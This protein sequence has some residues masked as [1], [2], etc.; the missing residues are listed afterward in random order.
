MTIFIDKELPMNSEYDMHCDEIGLKSVRA[1]MGY[2][3]LIPDYQ[4]GYRWKQQQV[5]DL[6]DDISEFM[7]RKSS[8]KDNFYCLQPLVVKETIAKPD[9]FIT[10]LP[11]EGK[12][13]L[14]K[15]RQAIVNHVE[16]EVID[17]QQ[18]LTTIYLILFFLTET[19]DSKRDN[20]YTLRYMT[21]DSSGE[22]LKNISRKTLEDSRENIDF[23]HMFEA[24]ATI[25]K[26]F[27]QNNSRQNDEYKKRFYN[28]LFDKVKFIWY[29]AVDK[30]PISVF[31]RLNIGKIPLTNAELI[32]ALFL[33]R[34][35]EEDLDKTRTRQ[36]EIASQWDEI[37]NTLQNDEFWM[38]IRENSFDMPTRIDFIFNL[39]CSLGLLDNDVVVSEND[40]DAQLGNDHYRTF[41]YFQTYFHPARNDDDRSRQIKECWQKVKDV[42]GA[43]LEWFND[44][45]LYHYVGY[46]ISNSVNAK[47]ILSQYLDHTK[48]K[49]EFI[50]WLKE[51]INKKI[52]KCK[53]LSKQYE[54]SDAPKKI[55]CLPLLLL[56]NVQ[57]IIDQNKAFKERKE[58]ELPVFYKFPFHLYKKESWNVEHI[59][60]NTENELTE[61]KDQN[62]WLKAAWCFLQG[63]DTETLRKKILDYLYCEEDERTDTFDNLQNEICKSFKL[64]ED[65]SSVSKLSQDEKNKI[66]NFTLLDECTNKSYGNSIFP[67]KKLILLG[68]DRGVEYAIVEKN[69]DGESEITGFEIMERQ[70]NEDKGRR[71]SYLT[72]FVPPVTKR[73][74][75]KAFGQLS[76]NP[77]SW[78]MEDAKAYRDNIYVVLTSAGFTVEKGTD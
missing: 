78:D 72:A 20:F 12:N 66:W 15:T 55:Q 6:L 33:S 71:K 17:G 68:K 61:Q 70:N 1:I 39:V 57:V 28:T 62:E 36:I 7:D 38:F 74:F 35:P 25:Q 23:R 43:F 65:E 63:D 41:R 47:T 37:E 50:R 49:T 3:F 58:Y 48:T 42:Y 5:S 54:V 16:W 52:S 18:R 24:Y 44:L 21:R 64:K 40:K 30:D 69:D 34:I 60:S 2:R 31:T 19:V 11:K 8:E 22:F 32:K 13:A 67:I 29:E 75:L 14:S 46:L 56:H 53:D 9:E 51:E 77:Y 26:W 10:E 59:D 45:T 73:V 27:G 4:R 76:N